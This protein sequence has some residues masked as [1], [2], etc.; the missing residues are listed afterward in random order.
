MG[1]VGDGIK[2]FVQEVVVVAGAGEYCSMWKVITRS[3]NEA[4]GVAAKCPDFR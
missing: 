4:F 3:N 1:V 2:G